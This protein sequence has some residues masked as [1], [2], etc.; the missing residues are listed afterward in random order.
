[1]T[2]MVYLRVGF[3]VKQVSLCKTNT[4]FLLLITMLDVN[5]VLN[6]KRVSYLYQNAL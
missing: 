3:G 4:L 5:S 2:V 1:M 6:Y